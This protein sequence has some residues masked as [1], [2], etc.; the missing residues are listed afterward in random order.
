MEEVFLKNGYKDPSHTCDLLRYSVHDLNNLLIEILFTYVEKE[1]T[2]NINQF[3]IMLSQQKLL[4]KILVT[5]E[6]WSI[7]Y[8]LEE[9]KDTS[10]ESEIL[11]KIF[12]NDYNEDIIPFYVQARKILIQ[13]VFGDKSLGENSPLDN[14]YI[15]ADKLANV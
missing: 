10:I 2:E 3:L 7:L 13:V 4:D 11:Y 8:S 1:S 12:N 9:H 14:V 5:K 15:S 6:I